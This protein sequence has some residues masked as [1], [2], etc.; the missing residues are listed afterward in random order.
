VSKRVIVAGLLRDGLG[1]AE[2]AR[3]YAD[4]LAAVGFDVQQHV[5]ALPGRPIVGDPG[6]AG[7]LPYPEVGADAEADVV[8]VYLNPPEVAVLRAH[9]CR[10]PRGRVTIG[11]WAWEVDPLPAAWTDETGRLDE[12]WVPSAYVAGIVGSATA[13]PVAVVPPPVRLPPGAGTGAAADARRFLALADAASGLQRKNLLGTIDAF[14]RAFEPGEGP[15][16]VIKVWNTGEDPTGVATLVRA[17]AGRPDVHVLDRW[18]DRVELTTLLEGSAALVSLHRAEGFGLPIFEAL[19]LGVPVVASDFSGGTDLLDDRAA[20]LVP[21]AP[22]VVPADAPPYPPGAVWGEPDADQAVEQLRAAW[23]DRDDALGRARRGQA[24]VQRTLS[25]EAVGAEMARRL[26]PLQ[27]RHRD[28]PARSIIRPPVHVV[29]GAA[30]PWPAIEPFLH[31][32]GPEIEAVGGEV[33]LGVRDAT[34][35]PDVHRP[36]WASALPAGST[37]PFVLRAAALDAADADLVVVTEDHCVPLP[38]WLAAYED[39]ATATRAPVLAG[40]VTNGS[41]STS[42]DWANYLIGFAAYAPPLTDVPTDRCPTIANCAVPREVLHDARPAPT[43]VGWFERDLVAELW[44]VGGTVLVPEAAVAHDQSFPAWQHL[45]NH[46][47]DARCA[48]AHAA[49][50]DPSFRP[51]LSPA[52]L[53]LVARTFLR[54]VVAAVAPRPDLIDAHRRARHWLRALAGARALGLALGA[55]FGAGRSGDRLD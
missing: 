54:G 8:V 32:V 50:T 30:E 19:A 28:R 25:A 38:G 49:D 1:L 26:E 34:V 21:T 16:L 47:D 42:A 7:L 39:A 12:V 24:M 10:L 33:L 11:A 6:P 17:A 45:R 36:A 23:F 53:A 29:V 40:A 5:V 55:R 31:A 15:E 41:G 14:S 27:A 48:G 2:G 44:R 18:L 35:L 4:A 3:G 22:G 46:F 9:R 52:A 20:H 43:P 37:N 13:V 51:G